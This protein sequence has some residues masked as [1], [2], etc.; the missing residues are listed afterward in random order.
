M[1]PEA[2]SCFDLKTAEAP[3]LSPVLAVEEV[4]ELSVVL[5]MEKVADLSPALSEEEA[6]FFVAA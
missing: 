2:L 4:T 3:I 1:G 6:E 5:I